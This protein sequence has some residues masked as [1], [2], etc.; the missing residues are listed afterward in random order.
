MKP[1][2]PICHTEM[3]E[4]SNIH[5]CP[6]NDIGDCSFDAFSLGESEPASLLNQEQTMRE[7]RSYTVSECK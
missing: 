3:L 2:C 4:R 7:L 1:L 6:R 5:I